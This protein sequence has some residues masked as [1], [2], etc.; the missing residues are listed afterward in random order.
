MACWHN[1]GG[2]LVVT[3]EPRIQRA[4]LRNL[5][6]VNWLFCRIAA[7]K[8]GIPRVHLFETLGQN[9]LLLLTWLPFSGNLLY[10]G[11]LSRRDTEIIILRVAFLRSSR[12]EMQQHEQIALSVGL[13][14]D[15]IMC[16]YMGPEAWAETS[17]ERALFTAVDEF[18][19][20]G[21]V[22]DD[23]WNHLRFYLDEP[24]LVEFCTLV[25]QYEALAKT[26]RTLRVP[27]DYPD[28]GDD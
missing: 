6:L 4:S 15:D 22:S 5:G 8:L 1:S 13:D 26:L 24:Q 18:V 9:K 10:R 14:D 19:L 3:N 12:Y 23:A 25:G 27:L 11:K 17:R 20:R 7:R 28:V 2:G 21:N 16:T